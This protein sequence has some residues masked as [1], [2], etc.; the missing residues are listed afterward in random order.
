MR[1]HEL[2]LCC[3][4]DE[5]VDERT[6]FVIEQYI[7]AELMMESYPGPLGQVV[8]NLINNAILHGYEGRSDGLIAVSARLSAQGWVTLSVED[9]G[10]GIAHEALPRIFD[11]FFTTKDVGKGT[12]LGLFLARELAQTNG[13]TLLYE[14]RHG[15]GSIFRLV[16]ADPRRWEA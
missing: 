1:V 11:P 5:L 12:G 10:A 7:P 14:P 16:F 2:A 9:H 15:G 6:P 8:T 3:V 4:S 13:A